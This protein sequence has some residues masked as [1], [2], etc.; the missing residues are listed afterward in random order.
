MCDIGATARPLAVAA[1]EHWRE[2][3]GI[4][5]AYGDVAQLG[6]RR[7]RNAK[8]GSSILLVST[9]ICANPIASVL[10]LSKSSVASGQRRASRTG[11]SGSL[12]SFRALARCVSERSI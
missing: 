5:R 8:V 1:P 7:V 10:R 4:I 6:G 2:P 12:L 11:R 9:I 3:A